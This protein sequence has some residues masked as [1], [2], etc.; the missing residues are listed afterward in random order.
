M[1]LAG[2]DAEGDHISISARLGS[3][4][5]EVGWCVAEVDDEMSIGAGG[6]EVAA[7]VG[8]G[9]KEVAAVDSASGELPSPAAADFTGILITL[10]G[11]MGQLVEEAM[12]MRYG[13]HTK[14]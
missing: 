1:G 10:F 8:A 13:P 9:G 2:G 6:K 11:M 12:W 4:G 7:A 14:R 5:G 3:A